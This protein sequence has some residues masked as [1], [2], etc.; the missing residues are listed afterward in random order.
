MSPHGFSSG[1]SIRSPP[2]R[3]V[4]CMPPPFTGRRSIGRKQLQR[5]SPLAAHRGRGRV[6]AGRKQ[7]SSAPRTPLSTC[8]RSGTYRGCT[9]PAA[10]PSICFPPRQPGILDSFL[11]LQAGAPSLRASLAACLRVCACASL[12][13][14][15]CVILA[16][17]LAELV[18][19]L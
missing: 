15:V 12:P 14:L 13:A 7:P 16:S 17:L 11:C 9:P 8:P 6:L 5:R 18:C 19:D 1:P 10:A 4:H 2:G 3:A